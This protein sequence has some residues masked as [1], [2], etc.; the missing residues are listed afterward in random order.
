[1]PSELRTSPLF[2]AAAVLAA[3]GMIAT[4]AGI[5]AL[6]RAKPLRFAIRT[7]AGL[8]LLALAALA[9]AIAVGIQ[10]YRALTREDIAA[11]M[12]AGCVRPVCH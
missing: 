2:L 4:V 7:L 1:M 3:C 6:A 9:G 8:L 11:L 5:V 12:G 10:G